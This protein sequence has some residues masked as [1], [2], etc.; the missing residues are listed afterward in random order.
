MVSRDNQSLQWSI[1]IGRVG[2]LHEV[3]L[4]SKHLTLPREGHLEQVIHVV[5][6]LKLHKKMKL[7]L[8][9]GYPKVSELWFKE[10]NWFDFY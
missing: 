1:E 4:L 3:L 6:Y 8:D 9:S 2:I 7:C 10:Y 5:G